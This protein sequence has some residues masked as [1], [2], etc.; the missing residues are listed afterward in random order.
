MLS[1]Q[2]GDTRPDFVNTDALVRGS[3]A[4][5]QGPR[6]TMISRSTSPLLA[7]GAMPALGAMP[8]A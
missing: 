8:G 4:V 5:Y 3:H 1:S 7:A 6:R 2:A